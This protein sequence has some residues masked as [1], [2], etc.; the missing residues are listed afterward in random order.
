MLA[1]PVAIWHLHEHVAWYLEC[2]TRAQGSGIWTR[3][4]FATALLSECREVAS[5]SCVCASAC[6][7]L[8]WQ[9]EK[10]KVCSGIWLFPGALALDTA[11][12]LWGAPAASFGEIFWVVSLFFLHPLLLFGVWI[13]FLRM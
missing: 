9:W 4:S 2:W 12:V 6:R 13:C 5:P 3:F 10:A 1:A 7:G 8:L 11:S